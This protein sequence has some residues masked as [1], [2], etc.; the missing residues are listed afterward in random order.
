MEGQL[1]AIIEAEIEAFVRNGVEALVMK[2]FDKA[3]Q[4]FKPPTTA[5]CEEVELLHKN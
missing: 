4:Y 3:K 2:Q 5:T 1:P